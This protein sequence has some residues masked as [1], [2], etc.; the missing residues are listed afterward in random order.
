MNIPID[1]RPISMKAN[2]FLENNGPLFGR[3][4]DNRFTLGFRVEERHCNP[5]KTCHGGMLATLADMTLL[6][7]CNLQGGIRQYLLTLTLTTDYLGPAHVGDWIEGRCE[8]LRAS[9]NLV[10]AQGLLQVEDRIV[11]RLNGIFKPT[12]EP[13]SHNTLA[14]EFGLLG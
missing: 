10:F 5:G 9:K 6:I 3:M 13:N 12:G 7:G 11:A 1:F 2:P 8:M 14:K 4:A